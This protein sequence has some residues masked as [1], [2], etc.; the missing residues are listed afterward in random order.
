MAD[1]FVDATSGSDSNDGLSTGAPWK[2]AAKVDAGSF[3]AGDTVSFKSG[4]EWRE[5]LTFPSSGSIGTPIVIGAYGTGDAPII[6]GAVDLTTSTYRW[7]ASGS[8]TNEWYVELVGGGDPSL[9]EPTAAFIDDAVLVI[10]TVGSLADHEWDWG[11]NDSLGFSTAYVR[12]NS[13]DPDTSG[14]QLE[15]GARSVCIELAGRSYV[16]VQDLKFDKS[17]GNAVSLQR[18]GGADLLINGGL[19]AFTGTPDDGTDDNFIGW[20]ETPSTGGVI[21]AVTTA[22]SALSSMP[23]GTYACAMRAPSSGIQQM[24]QG[25]I[26]LESGKT[27]RIT[28]FGLSDGSGQSR[29]A[30]YHFAPAQTFLQDDGTW[31]TTANWDL[32]SLGTGDTDW[33]R[34]DVTFTV[35]TTDTDYAIRIENLFANGDIFWDAF[36]IAEVVSEPTDVVIQRCVVTNAGAIGVSIGGAAPSDFNPNN[37]TVDDCTITN[38]YRDGSTLHPAIKQWGG[39]GQ[40]GDGLTVTNCVITGEVPFGS[41]TN[42]GRNGVSVLAGD[43]VTIESNT[44]TGVDHGI[45]VSG[46]GIRNTAGTFIVRYNYI[47]DTGDD[48]IWIDSP[49]ASD[50]QCYYNVI[51]NVSDSGFDLRGT[52]GDVFNNTIRNSLTQSIQ[53]SQSGASGTVKN[54][55]ISEWAAYAIEV[56]SPAT[57]ANQTFDYNCYFDSGSGTFGN[58]EETERTFSAWQSTHSQD[59]NS[60]NADPEFLNAGS[61]VAADY[62]LQPGSPCIDA[63]VDVSLT[64]DFAAATVPNGPATDIGA[65][66]RLQIIAGVGDTYTSTLVGSRH[67]T[68]ITDSD[69]ES[70]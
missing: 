70:V 10:G 63:G 6:S 54:N 47:H 20:T 29:V 52:Y 21:E 1:Y 27:Y 56:V 46:A 41:N 17:N 8:G 48:G 14:I 25:N 9:A 32:I 23:A 35:D 65:F 59:A 42:L 55:I 4:E 45:R 40:G 44:I 62:G 37:V 24:L 51:V 64:A 68:S 49:D 13:G 39:D 34:F 7:V 61:S 50:G 36:S 31:S 16:T 19:E 12:D 67:T 3:S 33:V 69:T 38:W 11:D 2:T 43:N 30:L 57:A 5:T 60:I 15:A 18:A 22:D 66:E 26:S 58:I 28:G 53:I